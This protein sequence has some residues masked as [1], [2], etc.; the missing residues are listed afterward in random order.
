MNHM[1]SC[2]KEQAIAS[3]RGTGTSASAPSRSARL[4]SSSASSR[5]ISSSRSA[6]AD[7]SDVSDVPDG[8]DGSDGSGVRAWARSRTLGLAASRPT[9]ALS[10]RPTARTASKESPPSSK[11][12]ALTSTSSRPRTSRY[13]SAMACSSGV[14]GCRCPSPGSADRS[15]PA[16][17]ATADGAASLTRGPAA[18]TRSSTRPA[19]GS[20]SRVA[21][22]RASASSM[23][24]AGKRWRWARNWIAPSSGV[25]VTATG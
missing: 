21:R 5:A 6:V 23:K 18:V 3:S 8:S 13:T 4:R 25:M 9:V 19:T 14:T 12:L 24:S 17:A 2:W 20:A 22:S 10:M 15:R 1:P 7:G 11:K 16:G